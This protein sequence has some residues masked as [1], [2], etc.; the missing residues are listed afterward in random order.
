MSFHPP[1]LRDTLQRLSEQRGLKDLPEF[2]LGL[3][4]GL[5]SIVLLHA[6]VAA[7]ITPKVLHIHHKLSS[8]ADQWAE[9]CERTC[10]EWNV[11]FSCERVAVESQGKGLE[12]AARQARYAAFENHMTPNAVLLTAHHQDD[13]AETILLRLM[14]GAG[15]KGLAGMSECRP[16]G[17]GELWRPLLNQTREALTAY[18]QQHQLQWVEDDSNQNQHF[19]RNFLRQQVMPLLAQ[20]WP[21]FTERW[22]H[23]ASLCGELDTLAIDRAKQDL[24][25][26]DWRTERLGASL[27]LSTFLTFKPARRGQLLRTACDQLGYTPPGSTHLNQLNQQLAQARPDA[28][29]D[30]RWSDYS[31]RPYNQRLYL[32][33]QLPPEAE[34]TEPR[35]WDG[36]SPLTF[37]HCRLHTLESSNTPRLSPNSGPYQIRFRQGGERCKP[38][39]RQH[40]QTLKK[41]LQSHPLEPWLR[42]HVPLIYAGETL[43]AV[44][45][46][47]ICEGF[48]APDQTLGLQVVCDY[49]LVGMKTI[50]I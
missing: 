41:L 2:Y 29:I 35:H 45:D 34:P 18:A 9:F 25:E 21:G 5:D 36:I 13:Q 40:S 24:N 49:S 11:P 27:N 10:L 37:K 6:L 38:A 39:G 50:I 46:L 19:D 31:L 8:L 17:Q 43:A 23:S 22:Q 47:W 32:L 48:Q 26:A 4:G 14:R 7:G 16:L 20:R 1:Y 12:D 15:P 28:K 30:V 44:G 42:P 33:P 3:S